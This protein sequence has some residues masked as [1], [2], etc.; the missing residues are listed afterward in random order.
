MLSATRAGATAA[1]LTRAARDVSG[2]DTPWLPHFYL[3]HGL[4]IDS[5]EMPFIG[6]DLG[7]AF[8]DN[9]VLQAGTVLVFE[10]IVWEDGAAGYRAEEVLVVTDDGYVSMTDYPYDPF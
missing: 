6:S 5:A 4:G 2:I 7:S 9:C 3:G 10:P 8:D 1:D